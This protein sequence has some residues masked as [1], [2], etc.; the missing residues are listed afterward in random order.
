MARRKYKT[1][2]LEIAYRS[3]RMLA[4]DFKSSFW[5]LGL[6]RRG[7]GHRSAYWDGRSGVRT[8]MRRVKTIQDAAYR[9]GQDDAKVK[10]ATGY[11]TFMVSGEPVTLALNPKRSKHND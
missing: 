7:A 1:N 8:T 10:G 3:C 11:K 2:T 4:A 6:P 9:A 5:Y